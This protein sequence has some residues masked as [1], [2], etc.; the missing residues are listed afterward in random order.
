[1]HLSL[2]TDRRL[3]RSSARSVR[4]LLISLSAPV[5]PPRAGRLPLNVALVLDR[6]GSMAGERKFELAREAL[7]QSLSMLR[8]EDRFT[9]VVYDHDVDVL[10]PSTPASATAKR[11]A[12]AALNEVGPRGSTNLHGGWMAGATE[13]AAFLNTEGVTRVLLLTDGLA[14]DGLAEP[15]QLASLAAE[16]RHRRITTSTFGVGDDFDERLL[17][18]IAHEGGGNFYF[19]ESPL[20]IPDLLTSELGEALAVVARDAALQVALPAGAEAKVLNRFRSTYAIGDNEMRVELGDLTSGQELSV[21]V[22]IR[23]AHG[24]DANETTVRVGLASG[25]QLAQLAEEEMSWTYAPHD[26]NDRQPRDRIVDIEAATLYAARARAEATEANRVGDYHRA[27]R[28]L[29]TTARRIRGYASGDPE[30]E[31]LWRQLL[32]EIETYAMEAMSPRSL[33]QSMF[34]AES[35]ARGRAPDGKARRSRRSS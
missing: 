9:I 18:D 27:R 7:K 33:K 32:A 3:L 30:L 14:N 23:F 4:H 31:R 17:R 1:M 16:L 24:V 12:L 19:V 2:R 21:V 8:P 11:R 10:V 35:A 22:R 25:D 20:Q 6:S 5:A 34:V 28:I 26:E 29:E 13:V 15:A